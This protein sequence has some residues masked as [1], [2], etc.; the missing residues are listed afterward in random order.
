VR[1]RKLPLVEN[2]VKKL[3]VLYVCVGGG[4]K[5]GEG[6]EKIGREDE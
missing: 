3:E 4:I 1:E 5:R 6:G 2:E